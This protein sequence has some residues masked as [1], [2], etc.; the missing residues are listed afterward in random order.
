MTKEVVG[1]FGSGFLI[2]N[3]GPDFGIRRMG[4]GNVGIVSVVD[5]EISGRDFSFL[6]VGELLVISGL[7]PV[8]DLVL[9]IIWFVT[10]WHESVLVGGVSDGVR[11]ADPVFVGSGLRLD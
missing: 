10:L 8:D 7:D 1:G 3:P 6:W 5:S 9:D 2:S 11:P 4:V